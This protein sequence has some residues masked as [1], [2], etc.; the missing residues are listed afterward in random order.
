MGWTVVSG[1]STSWSKNRKISTQQ[2]LATSHDGEDNGDSGLR[3]GGFTSGEN[4]T[5][6]R[7]GMTKSG[8]EK[9]KSQPL[10]KVTE[11]AH[12]KY[13]LTDNVQGL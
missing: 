5:V 11:P 4:E 13:K 2:R 10:V 6:E 7:E 9:Y 8:K 1:L 3:Y 12:C